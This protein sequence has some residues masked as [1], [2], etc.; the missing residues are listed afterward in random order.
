MDGH[1]T[2]DVLD[3]ILKVFPLDTYVIHPVTLM[4]V[5]GDDVKTPIWEEYKKYANI[6]LKKG[7][8]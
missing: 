6:I 3:A 2:S 1:G 4:G 8:I 5:P 7:V